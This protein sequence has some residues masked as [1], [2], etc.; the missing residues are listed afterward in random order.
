MDTMVITAVIAGLMGAFFSYLFT[1]GFFRKLL[2]SLSILLILIAI[3]VKV[4][5]LF[6]YRW[7]LP[8]QKMDILGKTSEYKPNSTDPKTLEK[9]TISPCANNAYCSYF[10]EQD[11]EG[12][13]YF[14]KR[15]T[16]KVVVIPQISKV[17]DNP[18][19][20]FLKKQSSPNFEILLKTAPQKVDKGN[21]VIKYG[22]WWRC[23]I[24][25]SNFNTIACEGKNREVS[26]DFKTLSSLGKKAIQPQT[27]MSIR[28]IS[29][30]TSAN[31]IGLTITLNY[32]DINSNP[33]ATT[34]TFYLPIYSSD[35]K[36]SERP[37]GVGVIDSKEEGIGVELIYFELKP[38]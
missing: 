28:L 26:R 11:W 31:K 21:I 3:F 7:I 10:S 12:W 4:P 14:Y 19:L 5:T 17:Q 13:E 8:L 32:I 33:E 18:T 35:P 37:I 29:E 24:A 23:I 2:I 36:I 30:I 15:G 38:K 34:M 6:G 20:W 27:E 9:P 16:N 1:K 25:E 22:D